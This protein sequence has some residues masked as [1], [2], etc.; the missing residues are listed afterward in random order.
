LLSVNIF[1]EAQSSVEFPEVCR[2]NIWI[3]S[4]QWFLQQQRQQLSLVLWQ[5]VQHY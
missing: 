5:N 1:G 2:K 4:S 3:G